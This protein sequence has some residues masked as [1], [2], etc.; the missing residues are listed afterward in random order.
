MTYF[1]T[2]RT[3]VL[4]WAALM[5][6]TTATAYLGKAG[7]PGAL[8]AAFLG[9]L[10]LVTWVKAG[11]ILRVYLNLR[12]APAWADG[13]MILVGLVLAMILVFF[14]LPAGH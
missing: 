5:L 1:P 14:A 3:L 7:V 11:L 10:A 13:L 2:R 12:T 6:A 4:G 9:G 8:P